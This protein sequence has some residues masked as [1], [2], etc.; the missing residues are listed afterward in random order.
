MNPLLKLDFRRLRPGH[1]ASETPAASRRRRTGNTLLGLTLDGSR[2]EGVVVRR[3]NGH[4]ECRQHFTASLSLDPL[5]AAPELVGREI[6]KHLDTAG[7]RERR[8]VVGLPTG[9]ALTLGV[10]LPPELPEADR[11]SFLQLEAERGFPYGP[12]SLIT[13]HSVARSPQ[14]QYLATLVAIPR[15]PIA[16]LETVLQAAQL[17]PVSFSLAI[18]ALLPPERPEAHGV[19]ALL[20]GEQHLILQVTCGGGLVLLRC[21]EGAFELEGAERRFQA[22]AIA[23]ELRITLGQLPPDVREALRGVR[24]LGSGEMAEEVTEQLAPRLAALGLPVE[25]LKTYPAA[26]G[27]PG[28][29]A[30]APVTGAISLAARYL[31]A[32]TGAFEFLPPRVSPWQ[33][34]VARYSSRRLVA[35]GAVGGAVV[36]LVLLA[37]GVQQ[38]QLW[39]WDA[40]W[41]EIKMRVFELETLQA[42]IRKYRPWF[43]DS[44]RSLSVLRRLTEAFPEDG[45][46]SAKTV[47]I[48]APAR[49]TCTGTA[50]DLASLNRTIEKLG[51]FP[52]VSQLQVEQTRGR[53]PLQF[54]FNFQWNAGGGTP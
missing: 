31:A 14:G 34:W 19:I 11:P 33:Q 38:V 9:W 7:I 12:E 8:C 43:D 20:P 23:R 1:S 3:T 28:P 36:G 50:R 37:F 2:L 47:E 21:L 48:R 35:A 41:Q 4:L 16:R 30:G 13:V 29:P 51:A 6:R 49:V 27:E 53:T 46:V 17:R 5:T 22:D 18:T 44:F 40:Q 52:E 10:T 39:Y 25:Q 45:V 24:V 42:N 32:G 54:S 26:D 15:D